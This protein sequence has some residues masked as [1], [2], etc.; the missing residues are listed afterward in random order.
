MTVKVEVIE[1][2][3]PH[4]KIMV[5]GLVCTIVCLYLSYLNVATSTEMFSFFGG[6]AVISAL[7]WGSHTIKVLCSYGIGTGVPSAGMIAFGSGVI[8]MLLATKFGIAAPIVALVLAA[9][10]GFILGYLSN[11]VLNMKIPVMI[12][13]LTELAVV[14]ALT[15]MG[16][17]VLITGS[18]TFAGLTSGSVTVFGSLAMPSYQA[19]FIGGALIAVAF[20]LG[21]IAIQHPFNACLGP[22]WK[23]DRM[24]MLTAECGF[25]SMI[26]A[27]IMSF[28]L[29]S[30]G[31]A[32]ISL[33]IALIGWL[34]TYCQYIGLSKRDAAAW[35]DT[36]PIPEM[37]GH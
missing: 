7:I 1:G 18:F 4:T 31:S 25:L 8:A 20:L 24:L 32:L 27:A 11:N 2:G 28:A 16:F 3:I 34:Y 23:Q 15:L 17:A 5:A 29:I 36:K 9:V 37:E 19:S 35:L 13:A 14:G 6:L 21:A 26:V 33:I 30:A 10:I 12:Q 22:G